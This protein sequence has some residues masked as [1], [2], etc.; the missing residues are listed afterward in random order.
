MFEDRNVKNIHRILEKTAE[1]KP[2]EF[3]KVST[4]ALI[5]QLLSSILI[6]KVCQSLDDM[7]VI[8]YSADIVL[9]KKK[10]INKNFVIKTSR[11]KNFVLLILSSN[12]KERQ[13]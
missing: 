11:Y 4:V 12:F 7:V 2:Y 13:F 5:W 8:W 9:E 3:A 6:T 10:I 1:C